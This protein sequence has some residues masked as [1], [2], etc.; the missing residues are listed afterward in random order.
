MTKSLT[1]LGPRDRIKRN[2]AEDKWECPDI[3]MVI[4]NDNV[5]NNSWLYEIEAYAW[6]KTTQEMQRRT[7]AS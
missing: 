6:I 7:N 3:P 5:D 1:S 4:L 2:L